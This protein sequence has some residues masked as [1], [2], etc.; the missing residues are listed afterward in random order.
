[1]RVVLFSGAPRN[2]LVF[3]KTV[4]HVEEWER[5]ILHICHIALLCLAICML[6]VVGQCIW[7]GGGEIYIPL[8]VGRGNIGMKREIS[9]PKGVFF[10]DCLGIVHIPI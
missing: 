7:R 6:L 10:F 1:M 5:S 8:V 4:L 2:M 9:G 3:I